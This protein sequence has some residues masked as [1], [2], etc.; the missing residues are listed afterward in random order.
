MRLRERGIFADDQRDAAMGV[1][2][3]GTVLRVVFED[4]DRGVVPVRAVGDGVDDA[5]NGQIVVG[6]GSC[7]TRLALCAAGGVIVRKAQENE[8]RESVFAGI[9]SGEEAIEL[10]EELID[11]ELIGIGNFEIRE[12]RIEMSAQFDLRGNIFGEDGNVPRI[13]AGTA[14]RIADI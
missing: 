6:N 11:A 5:A 8:L 7:G 10:V 13:R 1:D 4:E 3:V 12:E 2:V 14:A 9:A